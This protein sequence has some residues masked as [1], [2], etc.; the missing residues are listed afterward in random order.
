MTQGSQLKKVFEAIK[1]LCTDVNIDCNESG[2][3]LQ[4]MDSSHVS[5]VSMLLRDTGFEH[6]RCD[7]TM[8]LGLNMTN[9]SKIFKICGNDDIVTMKAEDEGDTI[10]FTFENTGECRN[11]MPFLE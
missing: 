11:T 6:Y 1:D 8:S 9:V 3:S 5:L 10:M 2:M 4:A 7:R